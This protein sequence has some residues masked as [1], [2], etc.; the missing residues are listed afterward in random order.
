MEQINTSG[1][2]LS[3][4]A[5]G[6]DVG[7]DEKVDFDELI[8]GFSVVVPPDAL[9]YSKWLKADLE[10]EVE[11]RN[12]ERAE[13]DPIVVEGNGTKADLVAALEAADQPPAD[14]NQ[15]ENT[16]PVADPAAGEQDGDQPPADPT[17]E[18]DAQSGDDTTEEN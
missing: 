11:R 9:P 5:L 13:D 12:T 7:P 15:G 8:P 3:V 10:A 14:P 4:P 17:D 2:T 6:R 1:A 18:P 16:D